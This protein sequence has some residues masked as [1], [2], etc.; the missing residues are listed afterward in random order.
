[1]FSRSCLPV[2]CIGPGLCSPGLF[3]T[4]N[5]LPNAR[6]S[7]QNFTSKTVP[8]LA[9]SFN[10]KFYKYRL[11]ILTNSNICLCIFNNNVILNFKRIGLVFNVK[12]PETEELNKNGTETLGFGV[13]NPEPEPTAFLF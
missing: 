13:N 7:L 12:F 5:I 9:F 10:L 3:R 2:L 8:L 6:K 4:E 1:M 11:I